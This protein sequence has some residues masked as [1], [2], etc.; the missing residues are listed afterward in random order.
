ML[1]GK[2][3]EHAQQLLGGERGE[4]GLGVLVGT[5]VA[6]LLVD[7]DEPVEHER[8]AGGAQ[9]V[10]HIAVTRL[11]VHAH[12]VEPRLGHLRGDGAL[13]DQAVE[14]ELVVIQDGRHQ[15][16]RAQHRRGAD[17]LVSLLGVARL[18]LVP[19]G[20]GKAILPAEV[21]RHHLGDLAE[22]GVGDVHR[23]GPHIGDEP[24]RTL[25]RKVDALVQALGERHGLAGAEPQLAGG[26]LLQ[27][28]GRERRRRGS[29]ALLLLDLGHAV[30]GT[31]QAFHVLRG[32]RL[33]AQVNAL[34]V[35]SGGDLALGDLHQA[36]HESLLWPLIGRQPD[37]DA[38]IL[39]G[40]ERGDLT[41]AFNDQSDR[42]GLHAAGR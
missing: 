36:S 34:L 37:V 18:R 23:V 13:P 27:R 30:G 11:D 7:T 14:A 26:L 22:R 10:T 20:L 25:A 5:L 12:L 16:G 24:D 42:D 28:R 38:P 19:A 40:V 3:L 29:L 4:H 35:R 31:V 1:L 39:D 9:A 8:L 41:L 6:P 21:G 17:R 32:I 15:V 2:D 33:R